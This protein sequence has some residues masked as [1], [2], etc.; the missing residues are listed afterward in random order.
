MLSYTVTKQE[1]SSLLDLDLFEIEALIVQA[2][3]PALYVLDQ[4]PTASLPIP[5]LLNVENFVLRSK[6]QKETVVSS[7]PIVSGLVEDP[8]NHRVLLY[9][10][11]VNLIEGIPRAIVLNETDSLRVSG[12]QPKF[13]RPI[14]KSQILDYKFRTTRLGVAI[15][16]ATT[17]L[18]SITKLITGEM[19]I[20]DLIVSLAPKS[21]KKSSY[22]P[23]RQR[24]KAPK[25]DK[26]VVLTEGQSC[27][28]PKIRSTLEV[29]DASQ[30]N[31]LSMPILV[32]ISDDD[33]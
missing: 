29:L 1:L 8:S 4:V 12:R 25:L 7:T 27:D 21:K 33:R 22:V 11:L 16:R 32:P 31:D 30:I 15:T 20:S 2:Y 3:I 23:Y 13:P 18:G 19:Q 10:A 24:P 26:V 9:Y 28:D 17:I 6:S 5:C 14:Y